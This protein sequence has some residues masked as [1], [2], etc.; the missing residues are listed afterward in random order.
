MVTNRR[1][2]WIVIPVLLLSLAQSPSGVAGRELDEETQAQL[3]SGFELLA[4]NNLAAAQEQFAQVIKRDFDNP[5]ANNNLAAI[6]EKQGRWPDAL[7][8]LKVA[9]VQASEYPQ[10]IE[11]LYLIGGVVAAVKPEK[12]PAPQ[13]QL[14]AI[15]AENKNKLMERLGLAG[16]DKPGTPATGK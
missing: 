14:A 8:Y 5:F 12:A 7:A 16:T 2:W 13:N 9:E 6:M 3:T 4:R 10:R 15:I 11:T 1:I